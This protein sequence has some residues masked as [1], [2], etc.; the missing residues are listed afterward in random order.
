MKPSVIRLLEK[1]EAS[2][3]GD[4]SK[5]LPMIVGMGRQESDWNA[6]ERAEAARY[7]SQ[8]YTVS[9]FPEFADTCF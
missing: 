7:R 8:G 9:S 1:I 2:V 6:D 4:R 5:E 3:G